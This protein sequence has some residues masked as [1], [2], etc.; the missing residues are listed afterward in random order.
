LGFGEYYFVN[1]TKKLQMWRVEIFML[2]AGYVAGA[3][4]RRYAIPVAV[5]QYVAM[6]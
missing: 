5:V 3:I 4:Q 6:Y 1:L 2:K